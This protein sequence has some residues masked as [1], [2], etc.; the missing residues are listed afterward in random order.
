[1]AKFVPLTK[2]QE[3]E[4]PP[5]DD[6][7]GAKQFLSFYVGQH[8]L[9]RKGL[10]K[11]SYI[12]IKEISWCYK[13]VLTCTPGCR[14]NTFDSKYLMVVTHGGQKM[15]FALDN[16]LVLGNLIQQIKVQNVYMDVGYFPDELG[17]PDDSQPQALN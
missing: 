15:K 13:H 11:I 1:M 9:F 6:F 14:R 7:E 17:G 2:S 8:Y 10:L 4:V 3:L 5:Q 12:P 16:G